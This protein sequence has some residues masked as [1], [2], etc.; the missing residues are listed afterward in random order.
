[1]W[2]VVWLAGGSQAKRPGGVPSLAVVDGGGQSWVHDSDIGGVD[3]R[4]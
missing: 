2:T 1:M 4:R 3:R